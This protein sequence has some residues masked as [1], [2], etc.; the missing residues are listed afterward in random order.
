MSLKKNAPL[1]SR[2]NQIDCEHS[3]TTRPTRSRRL[4]GC[5]NE[6]DASNSKQSAREIYRHLK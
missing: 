1:V 5:H 3:L 4:T 2:D 6:S